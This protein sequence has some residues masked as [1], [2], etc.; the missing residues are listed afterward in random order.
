[1]GMLAFGDVDPYPVS[2][3][4][5]IRRFEEAWHPDG[6][7]YDEP[8]YIYFLY[9][10][11][12]SLLLRNTILAQKVAYLSIFPLASIGVY[13]FSGLI[14][15]SKAARFI[16]SI[17][18]G[19]GEAG[20]YDLIAGGWGNVPYYALLPLLIFFTINALQAPNIW[21][22]V[23][24]SMLGGIILGFFA[25]INIQYVY[26]SAIMLA[27]PLLVEIMY[28]WDPRTIIGSLRKSV[29]LTSLVGVILGSGLLL[30]LPYSYFAIFKISYFLIPSSHQTEFYK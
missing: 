24:N 12:L 22:K 29:G 20:L 11:V 23:R 15:K 5:A 19:F 3:E 9:V 6:M 2:F 1:M 25:S 16:S 7:G 21:Q 26:W 10:A 4:Q 18:Y 14:V 13:I 28:S 30:T 17:I 8:S 27:V